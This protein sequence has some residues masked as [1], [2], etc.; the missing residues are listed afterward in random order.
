MTAGSRLYRRLAVRLAQH[1][2]W[3][4]RN[5]RSPW[6]D[7]A[8]KELD[9]IEDDA[10]AFCWSFGCALASYRSRL[11]HPIR[12]IIPAVWRHATSSGVLVLL[13]GIALQGHARGQ[14]AIPSPV[15][16]D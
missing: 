9:Y 1:A 12:F 6:A 7:A 11:A 2:S 14:T 3:V 16:D 10:A 8:R 13:I 4:L 5:G 15:F